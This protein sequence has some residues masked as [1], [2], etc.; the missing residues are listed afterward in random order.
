MERMN[1]EWAGWNSKGKR[2]PME[3]KDDY[4]AQ[5]KNGINT[6][7]KSLDSAS[8]KLYGKCLNGGIA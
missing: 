3:K 7:M 2:R 6:R 1:E 8:E 5:D 4:G